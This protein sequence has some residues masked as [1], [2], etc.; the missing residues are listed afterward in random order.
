MR[1]RE[2]KNYLIVAGIGA[3][4]GG[5]AVLAITKTIPILMEEMMPVMMENMMVRMREDGCSPAEM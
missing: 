2:K 5:I 1:Q 3:V 4:I